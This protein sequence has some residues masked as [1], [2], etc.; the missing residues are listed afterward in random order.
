MPKYI[1]HSPDLGIMSLICEGDAA[2]EYQYSGDS[3]RRMVSS[4]GISTWASPQLKLPADLFAPHSPVHERAIG[5]HSGMKLGSGEL[6]PQTICTNG[7]Q[8]LARR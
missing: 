2:Y 7:P 3:L 5:Q 1:I 6:V 8:H 4:L